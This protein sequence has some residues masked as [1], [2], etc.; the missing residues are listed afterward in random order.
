MTQIYTDEL[1]CSIELRAGNEHVADVEF[2]AVAESI[3]PFC[4]GK[5]HEG[6]QGLG[7][8]LTPA[9]PASKHQNQSFASP[10]CC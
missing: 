8:V 2:T 6:A 3:L 9:L 10:P 1:V 7:E 4:L 5:S